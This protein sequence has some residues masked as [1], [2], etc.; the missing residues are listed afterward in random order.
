[1]EPDIAKMWRSHRDRWFPPLLRGAEVGDI[2]VVQLDADTA[3]YVSTRLADGGRLDPERTRILTA[4]VKDL[5]TVLAGFADG[6]ERYYLQQLRILAT[7]VLAR[8]A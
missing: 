4:C 5:D 1:L 2:D 7:A 8:T 3:G 6:E